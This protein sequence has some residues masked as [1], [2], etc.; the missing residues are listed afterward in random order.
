MG[1]I[2]LLFFALFDY[3][4]YLIAADAGRV[5]MY[6]IIQAKVQVVIIVL[7]VV[8]WG[9][10]DAIIFTLLWWTWCADWVFYLYCLIINFGGTREY[11]LQPFTTE[12]RW[13]WWTP[14]GLIQYL[15]FGKEIFYNPE[16][17]IQQKL[18]RAL[19]AGWLLLQSIAGIVIS[20]IIFRTWA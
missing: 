8:F 11:W 2:A 19:P 17:T 20:I 6:R 10:T 7:L 12:I 13:A 3:F 16:G 18:F 1:Y 5:S 15:I 14:V 4:G 9:W